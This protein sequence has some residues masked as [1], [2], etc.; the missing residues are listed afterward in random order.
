MDCDF[1]V[2]T[3]SGRKR[4][5]TIDLHMSTG[6]SKY[7][8]GDQAIFEGESVAFLTVFGMIIAALE[9]LKLI[10]QLHNGIASSIES[11]HYFWTYG[12]NA[13]LTIIAFFWSRAE[14]QEYTSYVASVTQSYQQFPILASNKGISKCRST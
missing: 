8:D 12:P 6:H 9:A 2:L 11:R 13:I 10:S 3:P 7:P 5:P 1:L 14:F 4:P